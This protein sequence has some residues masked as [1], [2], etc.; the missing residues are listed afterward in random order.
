M[1][2]WRGAIARK[3]ADPLGQRD[4]DPLGP[5]TSSCARFLV[6]AH[7]ADRPV[8]VRS[9]AL[10]VRLKVVDDSEA[11]AVRANSFA[12]ATGDPGSWSGRDEARALSTRQCPGT[13]VSVKKVPSGF[14]GRT[15]E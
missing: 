12:M 9:Q 6:L 15:G 10:D 14:E 4:N 3:S 5:R 1:T 11:S 2:Q 13:V 7:A 8:P